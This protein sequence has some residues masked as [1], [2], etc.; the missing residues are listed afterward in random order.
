MPPVACRAPLPGDPSLFAFR[1]R[2]VRRRFSIQFSLFHIH[3]PIASEGDALT[4]R[5][6]LVAFL[7]NE[8]AV[9][10]FAPHI[11]LPSHPSNGLSESVDGFTR[12]P[13]VPAK[14]RPADV[15][16]DVEGK[17][18]DHFV[19]QLLSLADEFGGTA[20]GWVCQDYVVMVPFNC[21]KVPNSSPLETPVVDVRPME[22]DIR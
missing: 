14:V 13:F 20:M 10:E 6:S 3:L 7:K 21:A 22:L 9:L 5:R 16:F 18:H 17:Q 19:C 1:L 2:G 11:S 12:I 4:D 8:P 15:V